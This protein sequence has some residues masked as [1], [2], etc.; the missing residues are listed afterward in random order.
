MNW[1][2]LLLWKCGLVR[3][4]ELRDFDGE[5]HIRIIYKWPT[6]GDYAFRMFVRRVFRAPDGTL[7]NA[8]YVKE[9]TELKKSHDKTSVHSTLS[10]VD[11]LALEDRKA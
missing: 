2:K 7:S 5:R 9:W 6:G 1:F 8:S 11:K 10:R 4:C 3:L